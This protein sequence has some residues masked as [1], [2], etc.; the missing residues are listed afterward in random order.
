MYLFDPDRGRRRRATLKDAM[1]HAANK[2]GNAIGAT[3][4]DLFN[5]AK[6]LTAKATSIFRSNEA[7]DDVIEARVRSKLG[8]L[9][10]HP[11]SIDAAVSQGRV[12][13]TGSILE[14][15][16]DDLISRVLQVHGV[17]EVVNQLSVHKQAGDVPELQG[18]SSRTGDRFELL[19]SNWSPAARVL[20]AMAGGALVAE[21]LRRRG[22]WGAGLGL[23]GFGLMLRG[24]T[25]IET[26]R[27]FGFGGGRRAVDVQKTIN[28]D[29]PVER[30]FEFWTN[31]ANFP[32]F[33]HNVREVRDLGRGRSHWIVAGPAGL[34][35][36][37]N[38]VITEFQPARVIAWKSEPGSV[39]ANAGIIRFDPNESG[40]TRV[41]IRLSYNPPGGAMGHAVARVFGADPKHEMDE[42][43]LRLK[44]MIETGHPP[45]DAPQPT[46]EAAMA[47]R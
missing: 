17:K 30:V 19:Q 26:K 10:S 4:R 38:A 44:T 39:V 15:E 28:I 6:G 1:A 33:M 25:N 27:L 45:H 32:H 41:N 9:V 7:I 37:W 31:Y 47:A 21:A 24:I 34:P 23:F 18:G 12:T 16:V 40:G 14:R 22:G 8:R 11:G 2:T 13:L 43:L 42:D 46:P 5:R 3:S 29:A 36:E 35:V 20:T